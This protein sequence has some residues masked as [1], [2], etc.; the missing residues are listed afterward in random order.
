MVTLFDLDLAQQV[1]LRIV[2]GILS[3]FTIL[4]YSWRALRPKAFLKEM[5]SRTHSWWAI[6]LLYLVFFCI[7][8]ILGFVGLGALA[9]FSLSEL[10][11]KLDQKNLPNS[12]R[13]LA[14]GVV[15]IQFVLSYR[16]ELIAVS[17]LI[18]V[19]FLVLASLLTLMLEDVKMIRIGPATA[20]WTL[21]LT[22][23]GLSHLALLLSL[24]PINAG[25][26]SQTSG[27]FA[28]YLFLTQFNDVLQFLWGSL[29]GRHRISPEISPKK[30]WEGFLGGL[31]T[32]IALAYGLRFLTPFSETQS[33]IVGAL[34]AIT[35]FVGDLVLSAF[36][37][38]LGLKDM[39]SVI[40]GHGGLLDRIDSVTLSSITY[41]Y[42]IYYWFYSL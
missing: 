5:I 9:F 15:P 41:F 21:M 25:R 36:K 3:F 27:L 32:T 14:L 7:H 31:A 30:T 34:L 26:F 18:P 13:Y 1:L 19:V 11:D 37:R 29:L 40:P 6:V 39:G 16:A 33:L 42:L 22:T 4:F 12:L 24:P 10:M 20:L 8:P 28:Y 17:A 38:S 23:Y 2:F 35:G